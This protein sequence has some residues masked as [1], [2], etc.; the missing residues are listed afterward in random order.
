L[1][2]LEQPHPASEAESGGEELLAHADTLSAK[3][4]NPDFDAAERLG[5]KK[6]RV[7]L[8]LVC[9]PSPTIAARL[10]DC[11][12]STVYRHLNDPDFML[13]LSAMR[14]RATEQ[15]LD[16][17][18]SAVLSAVRTMV[19]L[20]DDPDSRVRLQASKACLDGFSRF[21]EANGLKQRVAFV[22]MAMQLRKNKDH[23]N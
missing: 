16:E 13:E 1:N 11:D 15:G 22:E 8:A 21:T 10:A 2:I 18:R 12:R 7:L 14:R 6:Y 17:L 4:L 19:D 20:L 3:G 23:A 9:N 5:A